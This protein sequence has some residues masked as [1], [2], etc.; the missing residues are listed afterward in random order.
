MMIENNEEQKKF[1]GIVSFTYSGLIIFAN[2]ALTWEIDFDS[3]ESSAHNGYNESYAMTSS[4]SYSDY[5]LRCKK[6]LAE[7]KSKNRTNSIIRSWILKE[8]VILGT[9][10][11]S[12]GNTVTW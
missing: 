8:C 1:T 3:G 10:Y 4:S 5:T 9:G 6:N 12:C 7:S 2:N 11:S